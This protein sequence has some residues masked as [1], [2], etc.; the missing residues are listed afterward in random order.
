ME[1]GGLYELMVASGERGRQSPQVH[2][3]RSD[4]LDLCF[5]LAVAGSFLA[6]WLLGHPSLTFMILVSGLEVPHTQAS[7]RPHTLTVPLHCCPQTCRNWW[8]PC[9]PHTSPEG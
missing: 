1:E 6:R 8:V 4:H 5:D 7:A 2:A 3:Q 9:R